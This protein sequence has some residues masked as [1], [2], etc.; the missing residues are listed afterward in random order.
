MPVHIR[1]LADFQLRPDATRR[2]LDWR[3]Q[4]A[5]E[6]AGHPARKRYARSGDDPLTVQYADL[7]H[8][9][10]EHVTF[11][12]FSRIRKRH[13]DLAEVHLA[14]ATMNKTELALL[15]GLLLSQSTDPH[16]IRNQTGLTDRQQNLYRRMFLDIEGRR[17]MSLFIASQLMEP[18]R[19][20]NTALECEASR[21]PESRDRA[22]LEPEQGSLSLRAQCTLRV[23]GFYGSP[24]VLELVYAG[25]LT[26]TVPGGRDSAVRFINQSTIANVH[27]FGLIASGEVPYLKGGMVEVYKIASALAMEEREDSQVDIIANVEALFTQ[28]RPRIGVASKILATEQLPPAVFSGEYELTEEE[29]VESM[30]TGRLPRAVQELCETTDPEEPA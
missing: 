23:I 7:L 12:D 4:R 10:H 18:S 19:L 16:L 3:F 11:E 21:R 27:R 30:Q 29:M 24:I 22:P 5:I 13:P 26:G 2:P 8:R 15:D 17:H 14:Y 20:R 9:L 28:F 25:F 1:Q 6:L